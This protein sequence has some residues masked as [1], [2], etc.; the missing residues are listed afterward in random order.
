MD[1]WVEFLR[2]NRENKKSH[3]LNKRMMTTFGAGFFMSMRKEMKSFQNY[4]QR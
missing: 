2:S 3:A 1:L 4:V